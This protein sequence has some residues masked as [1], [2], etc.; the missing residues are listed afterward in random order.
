MHVRPLVILLLAA[1]APAA[2]AQTEA[3]SLLRPGSPRVDGRAIPAGVQML[4]M[5]ADPGNRRMD[6]SITL[7]T[8]LAA[9]DGTEAIVRTETFWQGDEVVRVDSFALHRRTLAPLLWRSAGPQGGVQVDFAPGMARTVRYG[10]WGADTARVP[11]PEPVFLA[12]TTDMLLGALPLGEG[13][14]ARLAVY[15]ADEG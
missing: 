15:D 2:G 5:H 10:E 7:R 4:T 1:C 12:G 11:L 8:R 14:S 6:A 13:W 9:V 3:D